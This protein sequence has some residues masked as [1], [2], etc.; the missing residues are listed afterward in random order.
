MACDTFLPG[1]ILRV[2]RGFYFHYGVY[3]VGNMVVHFCSTG[4][5]ELDAASADIEETSLF[6]F[7][8]G[9][10]VS[11]DRLEEPKYNRMEVVARARSLIGTKLGT[12]NLP[13]NNCEHFA[14]WCRCGKLVSHQR[15]FVDSV[16]NGLLPKG[17][18]GRQL[19]NIAFSTFSHD[20]K[21]L[22]SIYDN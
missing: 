9:N 22:Q 2:F 3:V 19:K 21:K 1:T 18:F 5:N 11:E 17:S 20:Q 8:N 10:S 12:Y 6:D 14:N 7:S 16:V 13:S 15:N 4:D